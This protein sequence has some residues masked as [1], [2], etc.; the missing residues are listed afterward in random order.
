MHATIS[1]HNARARALRHPGRANMMTAQWQ[2][3]GARILIQPL[4][5]IFDS[6][7]AAA[8][9]G[10]PQLAQHPRKRKPIE[11]RGPPIDLQPRHAIAI[12]LTR[13]EH[14]AVGVRR[15]LAVEIERIDPTR[16]W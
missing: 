15:L 12:G 13:D 1:V 3:S 10:A 14:A 8:F 16:I 11:L 6:S 9:N 4:L 7:A 2:H 5:V